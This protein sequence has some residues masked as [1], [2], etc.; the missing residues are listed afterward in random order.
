MITK[1]CFQLCNSITEQEALQINHSDIKEA[2]YLANIKFDGCRIISIKESDDI[3]L[4]NRRGH[5]CN[6]SF[7]EILEQ[8]KTIKENFI[9]DGEIISL[10]DDFTQLQKRALTKD[11]HKIKKLV[12]EIPVKYMLFDILKFAD[13]EVTSYQ[14]TN[15]I[16]LLK[17][18]KGL[19]HIE[20]AEFKPIAEMIKQAKAEDRDGIIVKDMT[21]TYH[22]DR[23][24]NWRKCKFFEEENIKV[25]K[26]TENPKGIRAEDDKG[27]AVQIA[28]EQSKEVKE[29]INK[30]G[31]AEIIIQFLEKTEDNRYRFPSFRGLK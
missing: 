21:A 28:G 26:Y 13:K 14:Q 9:I 24:D 25:I 15:R 1:N 7:P 29:A 31:F 3:I 18:F 20:I 19:K 22:G 5:I 16:E 8:L 12:Q 10:N 11:I 23:N 2:S 4:L 27:N 6:K 17:E 30:N